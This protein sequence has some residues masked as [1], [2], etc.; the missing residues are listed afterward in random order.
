MPARAPP[1]PHFC[2]V[3]LAPHMGTRTCFAIFRLST[4]TGIE[5]APGGMIPSL[6][7]F[8][9]VEVSGVVLNFDEGRKT[10]PWVDRASVT[11]RSD[12]GRSLIQDLMI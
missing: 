4:V 9:I 11:S 12:G 8:P 5:V 10:L 2:R 1:K 7:I 6:S 3:S